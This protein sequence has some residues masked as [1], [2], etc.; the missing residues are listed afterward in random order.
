MSLAKRRRHI[1]SGFTGWNIF[2]SVAINSSGDMMS[3]CRTRVL[4]LILLI[5]LS[6]WTVIDQLV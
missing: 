1:F 5:C 4:A 3:P 2:S 6:R